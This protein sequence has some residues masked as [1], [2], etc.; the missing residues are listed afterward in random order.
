MR[1]ATR[2]ILIKTGQLAKSAGILPSKDRL[3]L[4]QGTLVPVSQTPG[5]YCLFEATEAIEHLRE[6]DE[7]QRR[8]RLTKREIKKKPGKAEFETL[9]GRTVA[10]AATCGFPLLRD[11]TIAL[12]EYPNGKGG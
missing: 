8:Q 11:V 2:H 1:K 10:L 3:Y 9:P 7:F 5:V 12:W 4:G 6:I